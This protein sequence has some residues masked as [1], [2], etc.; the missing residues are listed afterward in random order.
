MEILQIPHIQCAVELSH[1][2]RGTI[3]TWSSATVN[4]VDV[5]ASPI[6]LDEEMLLLTRNCTAAGWSPAEAPACATSQIRFEDSNRCPPDFE[7]IWT[8]GSRRPLCILVTEP[9]R[10]TNVCLRAG[11]TETLLDMDSVERQ[12][13]I[14]SLLERGVERVWMPASRFID[15]GPITWQLAGAEYGES[16]EFDDVELEET[17]WDSD[18]VEERGCF[19]LNITNGGRS[20]GDED[21][22]RRYPILCVYY[23]E[24]PLLQLAC[25]DGMLT[26]RYE[27]RQH[28]CIATKRISEVAGNNGA[29][30][31]RQGQLN[32]VQSECRGELYSLESVEKTVLFES[33]AGRANLHARD[34]C[35]FGVLPNV[36]IESHLDWSVLSPFIRYVNWASSARLGN[37]VTTDRTGKWFWS[38]EFTCIVC[39]Q[40][41]Q[42]LRPQINLKFYDGHLYAVVYNNEFLWRERN[43][44]PGLK[45]FTDSDNELIRTVK[46]EGKVWS[47]QMDDDAG[48]LAASPIRDKSRTVY[49]LRTYGDG[50]GYYW[51]RGHA[52]PNFKLIE[53]PPIVA[54]K[55]IKGKVFAVQVQT[56]C[57]DCR[58]YFQNKCI[59]ELAKRFRD[60]MNA[61][62]RQSQSQLADELSIENVRVMKIIDIN[63]PG[64]YS[65]ILFHVTVAVDHEIDSSSEEDLLDMSYDMLQIY[66]MRNFLKQMLT[67]SLRNAHLEFRFEWLTNTEYCLPDSISTLSALTWTSAKIGETLAPREL[68][69]LPSGLPVRRQCVGDFIFGGEWQNISISDQICDL[70]NLSPITQSLY[71]IDRQYTAIEST[72]RVISNVTD[73]MKSTNQS[74]LI[75]ADLYYL[76]RVMHS[77]NTFNELNTNQQQNTLS[78]NNNNG[79]DPTTA[80]SA[81]AAANATLLKRVESENIFAIYNRLMSLNENT[82]RLSAAVNATNVLLEALD[83]F[84]NCMS[85][86]NL[87]M[88][89]SSAVNLTENQ[90]DGTIAMVSPKLLVYV[91]DPLVR[92][93]SGLALM[94][95]TATMAGGGG[96]NDDDDD[97][98]ETFLDF[99]VRLLY[100]NQSTADLLEE[101]RLEIASFVPANL[102]ARLNETHKMVVT[103]AS[104]TT[105]VSS[106]LV[107][108]AAPPVSIVITVYYNDLLFQENRQHTIAK[109]GGKIISVSMPGYG[110]IL[111][112]LLPIFVR[113]TQFTN[114]T[115]TNNV[116]GYWDFLSDTWSQ[117]GC[118]FGGS[119]G[120]E[121]PT[122]LCACSHLT[123]F[124][125]LVMGTYFHSIPGEVN[126]V[127][128]D[129][130]QD[131]LDMIT[132]L[133]CSL[134]LAGILGIAITALVF[135]SWREKAGSKVLLHLSASIALQMILICFVNTEVRSMNYFLNKQWFGCV[136]M[137]AML[138]YSV[139][140]AFMWMLI[141]AYL[142]F[143]R[144]VRVIGPARSNRFFLKSSIFGW[145]VPLV[146]VCIIVIVAPDSYI[147]NLE[148]MDQGICYPT[149]YSLYLG[150]IMPMAVIVLANL[151]IFCMVIYHIMRGPDGKLRTS[152][153]NDRDLT[154]AQLRLSVLLFFLLGLTW[155][156][157][158]CASTQVGLV[159]S[160]LFCL[161]ATLQGFVLF[162]YFVILDPITRNLW[163]KW[164]KRYMSCSRPSDD[165]K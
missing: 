157:G 114:S 77:V 125:Y 72:S 38:D 116:C 122:V 131:A 70:N 126:V 31:R 12:L 21:C 163:G 34:R 162:L 40:K 6:C 108:A 89:R 36:L 155:I 90:L 151:V 164:L 2:D 59:R 42:M 65:N 75:P 140:V 93:V 130:H 15:F 52:L 71:E 54:Y 105:N 147:P 5:N 62:R 106:A 100:T 92:N 134:S 53:S 104:T 132:L 28:A 49:E 148:H 128:I 87:Q 32:W 18:V 94:R 33:L 102:L 112:V 153:A 143:L 7:Q 58:R 110:P 113:T 26:T 17:L 45:C 154:I 50:P 152:S 19:S 115:D 82:T 35:L 144:Y 117:D 76:G 96:N 63:I 25:P 97:V 88:M 135:P 137:G 138:H 48:W 101:E 41:L 107:A 66:L 121:E 64:N 29:G 111:P 57:I 51:C 43:D 4:S 145:G 120:Y 124:A 67:N 136:A 156:F 99:D 13:V 118:E 1:D 91:I 47:G 69:L 14:D 159:F 79:S 3:V 160:Y 109:P 56:H 129:N 142:Q 44:E 78:H 9:Q 16:V 23:E 8:S 10:W 85:P 139:L 83:N 150:V 146:P 95:K 27:G 22:E 68:C 80:T 81:T 61:L 37:I 133:G 103:N 158:L 98:G 84:V 73:L 86:S 119:S 30:V 46:I 149:G 141:T 11:T 161:T 24:R 165:L 39:E 74:S 127:H 123:H 55:H 20:G 60:Q